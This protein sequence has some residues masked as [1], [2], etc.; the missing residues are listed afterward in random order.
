MIKLNEL[1]GVEQLIA[2]IRFAL[3]CSGFAISLLSRLYN[4]SID[5]SV[6]IPALPQQHVPGAACPW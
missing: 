1:S 6:F 5:A 2:Y 3:N 4:A